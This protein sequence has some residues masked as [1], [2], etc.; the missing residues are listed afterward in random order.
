MRDTERE[1]ETK[2]QAP[3]REP[4]AGLDP[5]AP[6][7]QPEPKADIQPLNHPGAPLYFTLEYICV[8]LFVI[9]FI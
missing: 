9:Q 5:R 1:A 6:G 2:K 4:D 3:S 7:S 8:H